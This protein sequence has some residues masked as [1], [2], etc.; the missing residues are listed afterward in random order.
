MATYSKREFADKCG[1]LSRALSVYVKRGK[2][3]VGADEMISDSDP[4]NKLFMEKQL[5][6][7][8]RKVSAK[9]NVK[10]TKEAKSPK[11]SKEEQERSKKLSDRMDLDTEK[12]RMAV[13]KMERETFLL[14]MQQQKLL[15]KLIPTD[16]VK[17][18]FGQHF[19]S[20]TITFKQAVDK[21]LTEFAKKA[22]MDR[23]G[24]AE[25]RMELIAVINKAV[26]DG[27]AESKKN[28]EN[29]VSEYSQRGKKL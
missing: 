9:S 19:K 7:P 6:N 20:V 21:L 3:V 29:I 13:R 16:L 27:I 15:G 10:S 14:E 11:Q 12:Q 26:E 2:V 4:V 24:V 18:L 25:M 8:K 22:K 23:N 1:M 17:A 5:S 28:I